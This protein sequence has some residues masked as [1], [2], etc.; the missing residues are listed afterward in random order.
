MNTSFRAKTE[1]ARMKWERDAYAA[2]DAL[3]RKARG[4][5]ITDG[6]LLALRFRAAV[7]WDEFVR[8]AQEGD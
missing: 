7:S 5:P 2:I 4:E 8:V 1:A 3:E 6:D